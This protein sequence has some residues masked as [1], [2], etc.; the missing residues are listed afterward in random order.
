MGKQANPMYPKLSGFKVCFGNPPRCI[1]VLE[2][3]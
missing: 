2:Y 3:N 1:A